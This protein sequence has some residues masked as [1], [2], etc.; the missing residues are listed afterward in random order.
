MGTETRMARSVLCV[1]GV[2]LAALAAALALWLAV[3]T[4]R[5]TVRRRRVVAGKLRVRGGAE[6]LDG[7]EWLDGAESLG[8]ARSLWLSKFARRAEDAEEAGG[9]LQGCLR[10]VAQ[11]DH[12]WD[13]NEAE[14][15][16]VPAGAV[17][18]PVDGGDSLGGIVD[19]P[20]VSWSRD[21]LCAVQ[22]QACPTCIQRKGC[23]W[24][25]DRAV[26]MA[27]VGDL[28]LTG[29]PSACRVASLQAG[30]AHSKDAPHLF[31]TCMPAWVPHSIWAMLVAAGDH[32]WSIT[33]LKGTPHDVKAAERGLADL[34]HGTP[35]PD[36]FL[37]TANRICSALG[38][39]LQAVHAGQI[40]SVRLRR[41][42]VEFNPR[43]E[44]GDHMTRGIDV[45]KEGSDYSSW[46]VRVNWNKLLTK[47]PLMVCGEACMRYIPPCVRGDIAEDLRTEQSDIL[48][49]VVDSIPGTA[50][51]IYL[52][53][54]FVGKAKAPCIT[55]QLEPTEGGGVRLLSGAHVPPN[56]HV[57]A[58]VCLGASA[59][60]ALRA[61][62]RVALRTWVEDMLSQWLV[63]LSFVHTTNKEMAEVGINNWDRVM[64]ASASLFAGVH[65]REWTNTEVLDDAVARATREYQILFPTALQETQWMAIDRKYQCEEYMHTACQGSPEFWCGKLWNASPA[66]GPPSG[67]T[68]RDTDGT[69]EGRKQGA[70]ET[71]SAV[72]GAPPAMS[73]SFW[74]QDT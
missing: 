9:V 28:T 27:N 18:S 60:K 39:G 33:Y 5:R 52:R 73:T 49:N 17:P 62:D 63:S 68:R 70:P 6:S 56:L 24:Q 64:S 26:C 21:C 29:P 12:V 16:T 23:A 66:A 3:A 38:Q 7:A 54:E 45:C 69:P 72:S 58:S 40:D 19:R 34:V 41:Y 61:E 74:E 47:F 42:S 1:M 20:V 71:R 8:G 22:A 32:A 15:Y 55:Y 57:E 11:Q 43:V 46:V 4:A 36:T 13:A 35:L 44:G 67:T 2:A 14:C 53:A 65:P 30:I 48:Q 10:C 59:E 25:P 50:T 51:P 37:G 31:A